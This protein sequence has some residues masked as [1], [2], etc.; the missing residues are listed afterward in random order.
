YLGPGPLPAQRLD[1][2]EPVP[3]AQWLLPVPAL[4]GGAQQPL[5]DR[6][7]FPT[8]VAPPHASLLCIPAGVPRAHLGR[9]D[10]TW[11]P[12]LDLAADRFSHPHARH[13]DVHLLPEHLLQPQRRLLVAR[14]G[15]ATLSHAAAA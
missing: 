2:R 10:A 5:Q 9:R 13:D 11:L 1:R 4:R 14:P 6:C 15:M 7:V 8:T 12:A 3:R